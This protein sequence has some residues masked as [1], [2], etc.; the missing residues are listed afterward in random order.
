M[1]FKYN[2]KVFD[3]N[4]KRTLDYNPTR[5]ELK[6]V[7]IL[8]IAYYILEE[9]KPN[10]ELYIDKEL[11]NKIELVKTNLKEIVDLYFPYGKRI[12]TLLN[13]HTNRLPKNIE[14]GEA[15]EVQIALT[16]LSLHLQPND[17][18]FKLLAETMVDFWNKNK[19]DIYNILERSY[20]EKYE[21]PAV[22]SEKIALMYIEI[23]K[24]L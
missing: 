2:E 20:D 5:E 24:N 11:T 14:F 15:T 8:V 19:D 22:G 1:K 18:G 4:K 3:V 17:R 9:E 21:N 23:M 7:A 16:L 13:S 12:V 10:G 6:D